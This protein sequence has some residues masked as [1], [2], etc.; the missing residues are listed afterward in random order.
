MQTYVV[1]SSLYTRRR[2]A[3]PDN[4][5]RGTINVGVCTFL[6][7]R[8]AHAMI[9]GWQR[10]VLQRCG[11]DVAEMVGVCLHPASGYKNVRVLPC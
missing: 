2:G 3:R 7:A 9:Y 4:A 1:G 11:G 8:G 10:D 5:E 6:C